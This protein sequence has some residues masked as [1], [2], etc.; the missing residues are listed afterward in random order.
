MEQEAPAEA[1]KRARR[2]KVPWS[3]VVAGVAVAGAILYLVIANTGTTAE[4]YMTIGELRACHSC[5]TQSV[6]V[7]GTV[8]PNSIVHENDSQAVRFSMLDGSQ[9]MQVEYSGIVPDIFRGGVQ[10]VVDGHLTAKGTFQAQTLLAKCP[11]K[12][13]PA[14]PGASS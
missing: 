2:R 9:S 12:F 5:L 13:T 4:Y 10:V 8:V 14:P 11:S 7:L 6:R 1:R 3:F